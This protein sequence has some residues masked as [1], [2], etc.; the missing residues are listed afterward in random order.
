MPTTAL[1]LREF[2]GMIEN[3]TNKLA[4]SQRLSFKGRRTS[5][6]VAEI[7]DVSYGACN[8]PFIGTKYVKLIKICIL[9][10]QSMNK[11]LG[12]GEGFSSNKNPA[13]G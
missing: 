10:L 6:A 11:E 7:G 13:S 4:L 2:L 1:R 3:N 9:L 5:S 8:P 12:I